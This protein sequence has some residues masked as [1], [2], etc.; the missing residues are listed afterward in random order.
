MEDLFYKGNVQL[1]GEFQ[2]STIFPCAEPIPE[3]LKKAVEKS[4]QF[5]LLNAEMGHG[6]ENP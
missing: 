2:N 6:K 1:C 4:P 5:N 3:W